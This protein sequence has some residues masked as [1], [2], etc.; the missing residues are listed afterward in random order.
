[1]GALDRVGS[2]LDGAGEAEGDDALADGCAECVGVGVLETAGFDA[3]ALG[4]GL[5][6]LDAV[7]DGVVLEVDVA[8]G[9]GELDAEELG[10][11][12]LVAVVDGEADVG[13]D[14]V[15]AVALGVGL[16]D[17]VAWGG[18][19]TVHRDITRMITMTTR[20]ATTTGQTFRRVVGAGAGVLMT[21][22]SFLAEGAHG[23]HIDWVVLTAWL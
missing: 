5:V 16:V 22:P 11:A 21:A 8:L 6:E 4:D 20:I 15:D 17:G 2:V 14:E 10:V 3:E 23:E 12:L 7:G 13:L 19:T 1:M 9:D 18:L